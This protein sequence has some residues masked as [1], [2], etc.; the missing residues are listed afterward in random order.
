MRLSVAAVVRE[1]LD[2]NV[3]PSG[4]DRCLQR[5]GAGN[6]RNL[7]AKAARP[8]HSAFKAY[9]RGYIHISVKFRP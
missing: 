2:P 5:H 3:S 7:T 8:K 4:L 1:F 6:L 9:E